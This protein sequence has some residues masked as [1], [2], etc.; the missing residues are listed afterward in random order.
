M[1]YRALSLS[2]LLSFYSYAADPS[3]PKASPGFV[4]KNSDQLISEAGGKWTGNPAVT[5]TTSIVSTPKIPDGPEMEPQ[6]MGTN[7]P[8]P[9]SV[10][11]SAGG[12]ILNFVKSLIKP[13]EKELKRD[14]EIEDLNKQLTR[15]M[16]PTGIKQMGG[17]PQPESGDLVSIAKQIPHAKIVG[18]TI[19]IPD[20]TPVLPT[21]TDDLSQ[22]SNLADNLAHNHVTP[23]PAPPK[24]LNRD[25]Q[26][27][28]R[29]KKDQ[30][31][32][33]A[34]AAGAGIGAGVAVGLWA[35]AANMIVAGVGVV[36]TIVSAP[37]A[38]P[39]AAGALVGGAGMYALSKAFS[40][41]PAPNPSSSNNIPNAPNPKKP[42][43]P[44]ERKFNQVQRTEAMEKIKENYRYDKQTKTYI[45]K[46]NGKAI[47]N[48]RTGK[49]VKIV[50]WDKQHGD[51]EAWRGLYQGDHLGSIDPQTFEMY[52][53]P[54]LKRTIL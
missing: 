28:A 30:D 21:P 31:D 14:R 48:T 35:S 27:R 38:V 45:L 22:K 13:S 1:L 20:P 34:A 11:S 19:F 18:D 4:Q 10:G 3:S 17:M 43:E 51:I 40:N 32:L 37:V 15:A 7:R 50:Y 5:G 29:R 39:I 49:P 26:Q 16:T 54:D 53:G 12:S 2:F 25:V 46:D 24:P 41:A 42:E 8:M 6:F 44:K 36:G 47:M 9:S 23:P 33:N 52:K